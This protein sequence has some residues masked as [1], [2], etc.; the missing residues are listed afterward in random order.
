MCAAIRDALHVSNEFRVVISIALLRAAVVRRINAGITA[1]CAHANAGVIRERRQTRMPRCV[2]RFGQCVL[3][4]R[5]MWLRR[6]RDVEGTLRDDL[7]TERREQ[8]LELLSFFRLPVAM[9][10]F[11][12]LVS[13]IAILLNLW[14]RL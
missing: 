11:S 4:K 6:F 13:F 7:D 14:E 12:I 1:E 2:A 10:S 3:K 8:A 5:V 9:T